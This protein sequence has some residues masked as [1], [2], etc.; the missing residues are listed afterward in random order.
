MCPNT[1]PNS[2]SKCDKSQSL[3]TSAQTEYGTRQPLFPKRSACSDGT[4]LTGETRTIA[5]PPKSSRTTASTSSHTCGWLRRFSHHPGAVRAPFPDRDGNATF[6]G[7]SKSKR[8]LDLNS[9]VKDWTLHDLRRVFSTRVAAYAQPHVLERILNHSAGQ[10]SGVA[11]IY[12]Q[13]QYMAEMREALQK[14]ESRPIDDS[15][16]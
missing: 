10:I 4:G 3:L 13:F 15:A 12:N 6:Q 16:T 1:C 11:R 14:W 7:R 2:I 9:G 5:F 8:V